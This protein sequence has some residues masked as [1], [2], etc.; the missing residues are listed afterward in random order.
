V[1]ILAGSIVFTLS[2][3]LALAETGD[4]FSLKAPAKI[5]MIY[6]DRKRDGGWIGSFEQARL[7][8]E[9][10]L[11]MEIAYEQSVTDSAAHAIAA[12]DRFIS[13]GYNI[14]IGT[15]SQYSETFQ[16]LAA[17]HPDVA[18][19]NAAGTS[20][21]PNLQSFYGRSFDGHYLC[22]MVAGAMS[23]HHKI[24]YV[25]ARDVAVI[26][27]GVNGFTL[28]VRKSAPNTNVTVKYVD[29]WANP[30]REAEAANELIDLGVDVIGQHVNTPTV[31]LV[32]QER[33]VLSTGHHNDMSQVA[34]SAT[35]CSS[36]WLWER[37]LV[38]EMK[39]I[40]AGNWKPDPLGALP[41]F[42]DG[43]IDIVLNAD[44]VPADLAQKVMDERQALIDGKDIFAGPLKDDHGKLIFAEG[45]APDHAELHAMN[46]HVEGVVTRWKGNDNA[47]VH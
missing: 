26:D 25:A 34:P 40:M 29:D 15:G 30:R 13:K 38:P 32:A 4:G 19:L 23:P 33:G 12:T 28:G 5:A 7:H 6:Y 45:E 16:R 11:G 47:P 2:G 8:M 36:V 1:A 3:T 44:L 9:K 37:Y 17:R 21:S 46:W 14:I 10:E 39:K 42:R 31:Q 24:G 18:F 43:P 22:G 27:W 35:I 20:N 41:S